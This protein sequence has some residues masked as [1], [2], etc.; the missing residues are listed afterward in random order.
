MKKTVTT[1]LSLAL[2]LILVSSLSSGTAYGKGKKD[3]QVVIMDCGPSE[4]GPLGFLV[5]A[6]HRNTDDD[7]GIVVVG[8]GVPT[9]CVE[10]IAAILKA[11]LKMENSSGSFNP[12]I[13]P[14]LL[15]SG[16]LYSRYTFVKK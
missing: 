8:E 4:L 7:F 1:I 5:T 15:N 3:P 9:P 2:A 10:A 14:F 6:L 13:A 16:A 12:E 11:R